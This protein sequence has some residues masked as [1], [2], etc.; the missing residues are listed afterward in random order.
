MGYLVI[1]DFRLGLDR[2]RHILALPPGALY[3]LKNGHITRGGEIEKRKAFVAK[4]D[5]PAGDTFGMVAAGGNIYVFGSDASP[6]VPS[7]VTYQRLQHPDS[8]AMT[9]VVYTEVY[10]GKPYVIAEYEGG[11]RAHFYDG[12]LVSDWLDGVVRSAMTDNDGIATH[13]AGIVDAHADYSATAAASVITITG[14]VGTAF[15]ISATTEDGGGTDDQTA[16]VATTQSAIAGVDEV[17]AI[18]SFNVTG[19]TSSAGVNK[20]ASIKV[21]GIEILN[22]AVD[23]TV[24]NSGTATAIADQINNYNSSPEYTAAASGPTLTIS[25]ATGSGAAPNNKSVVVTVAGD[26]TTDA[27]ADLKMAG[28]VAAVSGQ[29]QISTVTIG[30]TFEHTDRFT[31]TIGEETFGADRVSGE[32]AY[33]ARTHKSKIY[34]IKGPN[35]FASGVQ[36]PTGWQSGDTGSVVIDMSQEAA[37]AEQLTA[38]GI[39]QNNLAVFSRNTCQIWFVD[40]DPSS[41]NQLQVLPNIG[42]LAPKSVVSFGEADVFFLSDTGVRS[43]RARDSSNNAAV[44]DVGTP[45]DPL[46]LEALAALS[47]DVSVAACAVIDPIDGRYILAIGEVCY[48]F[49]FFPGS[50]ISAWS[51]YEPGFVISDFTT[52]NRRIYARSGDTIYLYGGDDNAT[53]D[54][55]EL[56]VKLPFLNARTMATVKKFIGIDLTLEGL[57][58]IYLG[59]DPNQPEEDELWVT[60]DRATFG[61]GIVPGVAQ[62]EMFSLRFV[63]NTA[64]YARIAN[65]IVHYETLQAG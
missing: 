12:E 25:A 1:E 17:L 61:L 46:V 18:A 14:P 58:N 26:V 45:I 51:T 63:H 29:A 57:F 56:E 36:L 59:T 10:A 42:A 19:G 40:S 23:W 55:S 35:L 50:K 13:L 34:A 28:G 16:V 21:D 3:R 4:Y 48:V 15:D 24:S 9:S 27:A 2:R 37:G 65:A 44:S 6:T 62:G 39:Y 54:T 53:Y 64:E 38:L 7:G 5:L 43:L 11:H 41:N 33:A 60:T 8:Y 22:V 30:G 31:I 49:S 52:L 20:V 32:I 47:E